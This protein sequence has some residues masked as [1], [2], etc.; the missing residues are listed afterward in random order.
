MKMI[1]MSQASDTELMLRVRGTPAEMEDMLKRLV[2]GTLLSAAGVSAAPPATKPAA[3]AA[4][5]VAAPAKPVA[6]P[7]VAKPAAVAVAPAKPVAAVVKPA[8]AKPV[9]PPVAEPDPED[10]PAADAPSTEGI[11]PEILNAARM[12]E[13]IQVLQAAGITEKD[14]IF[15]W[16]EQNQAAVPCLAKLDDLA[17]RFGRACTLLGIA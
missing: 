5:A 15:A 17:D 10:A 1:E 8:V 13:V 16:L 3:V 4:P 7:A 12:R 9:A 14:Q 6:A 11:P 2:A